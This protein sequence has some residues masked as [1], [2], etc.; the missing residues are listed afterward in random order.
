MLGGLTG[1]QKINFYE[2]ERC[3]KR[4][5]LKIEFSE[6]KSFL[7]ADILTLCIS[8]AILGNMQTGCANF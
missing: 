5:K 1:R 6:C 2:A 3:L 7:A 4:K 8:V